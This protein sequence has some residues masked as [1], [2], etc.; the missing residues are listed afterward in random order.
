MPNHYTQVSDEA[1]IAQ[2]TQQ[3]TQAAQ[4]QTGDILGSGTQVQTA[5][6]TLGAGE[7]VDPSG[8]LYRTTAQPAEFVSAGPAVQVDAPDDIEV[9]EIATATV[10]Q[11]ADVTAAQQQNL[12]PEATAQAAVEN[13]P[14]EFLV[15]SQ[16]EELTQGIQDGDIPAWAQPAA[17]AVE[18]QLAARGLTRSSVGQAALTNAI[19]QAALPLAQ[20]N[21]Q[22][23]QQ[24]FSQNLANQQAANL[25]TAAAG[26]QLQL[27]N[28]TNEQQANL[29]RSQQ[30]Q[31]VLLSDQA[32]ENAT[33]QFN[34]TNELQTAQF[35]TN[36]TT[37]VELN[38]A[39][40]TDAMAQF[41]A[42]QAN[43]MNQ[44]NSNLQFNS[45]R[46]NAE[47]ATLIAQSNANWFRTMSTANTANE[48]QNNRINAQNAYNLQVDAINKMWQEMRDSATMLFQGAQNDKQLAVQLATA[49]LNA[50]TQQRIANDGRAS[51]SYA[52]LGGAAFNIISNWDDLTKEGSF[53]SDVSSA[54]GFGS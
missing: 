41:N 31:Q 26:Q 2:T 51:S 7:I 11:G 33:R 53:I 40:R 49:N 42:G 5:Q 28:L 39:A 45:D 47:N 30:Q 14:E 8:G 6:Q 50:Q 3:V 46:F 27:Q 43:A 44:F 21:A 9:P 54:L 38:N 22:A 34:A 13:L 48:N 20:G 16:M 10:G 17:D 15:S 37:Q 29:L 1:K 19:I 4:G 24:N 35:M 25:Q 18:A 32:A 23:L 12:T 52:A 36:L